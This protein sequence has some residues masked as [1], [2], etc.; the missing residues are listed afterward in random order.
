M[1]YMQDGEVVDRPL[2]GVG[3]EADEAMLDSAVGL[4]WRALVLYLLMLLLI[5]IAQAVR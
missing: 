2:L 5:G 3:E 4:V 1:P